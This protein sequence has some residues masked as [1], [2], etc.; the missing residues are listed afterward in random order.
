MKAHFAVETGPEP[1]A[2][3]KQFLDSLGSR[4]VA[5]NLDPANL[6]MVAGDEMC[7]R[8]SAY[9]DPENEAAVQR[10]VAKLVED[11]TVIVIA[12]RLS[13]ITDADCIFV[14]DG[15]RVTAS[16]TH[17]QLLKDS[18]LYRDCLLYTSRCV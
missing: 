11:K 10:A 2:V 7:I 6:V 15:G 3:L 12:H 4:G 5:V 13:T 18:E 17:E 8:D 9:I 1:A 16:G 14:I